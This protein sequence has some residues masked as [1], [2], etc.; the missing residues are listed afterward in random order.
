MYGLPSN[1]NVSFI[2]NQRLIQACFGQNDLILKFDGTEYVSILVTSAIGCISRDGACRKVS[3]SKDAASFVLGLV[4]RLVI[5]VQILP[6]GTLSIT[7]ETRE[8][9]RLYDDSQ[10]FES[11]TIEHAGQTIVV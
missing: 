5:S 9:I 11:Y 1:T 6:E 2:E 4:G 3:A 8:Q 7:F 10:Q